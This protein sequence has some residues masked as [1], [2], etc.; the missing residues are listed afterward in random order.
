MYRYLTKKKGLCLLFSAL[1]FVSCVGGT[2]FSLVMSALIDCAGKGMEELLA[3]LLGSIVYVVVYIIFSISYYYVK[4]KVL[5]DA[6]YFLKRDIFTGV[7]NRSVA[8]FDAGSN[9]EYI[10]ELSNHINLFETVYFANIIKAFQCLLSFGSATAICI[11]VQPLMLILMIALAFLTMGVTR[12]AAKPLE[13]SMKHFTDS[14]EEYTAEIK[15]DL[16]GFRLI[17]S[18]GILPHILKKHDKKNRG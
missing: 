11:V 14:M 15:D 6:R 1:L 5:T 3:T 2:F 10:N 17:H 13:Q 4:E 16:E 18:F 9:G 12:L 8:E 7:M